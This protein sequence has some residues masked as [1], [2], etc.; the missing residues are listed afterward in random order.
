[1]LLTRV[2][3]CEL[4]G[5]LV[6]TDIYR[7]FV[8]KFENDFKANGSGIFPPDGST[9]SMCL[10]VGDVAYFAN[11]GDSSM[12][13]IL[14]NNDVVSVSDRHNTSNREE[15]RRIRLAGGRV[16]NGFSRFLLAAATRWAAD[17]PVTLHAGLQVVRRPFYFRN[18]LTVWG[19]R[20][21]HVRRPRVYPGGLLVTR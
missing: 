4:V 19:S 20:H 5:R 6:E 7:A 11:C 8:E 18:L 16:C 13:C 10:I 21:A 12:I 15:L 9:A 14:R 3:V 1:M 2:C 17:L